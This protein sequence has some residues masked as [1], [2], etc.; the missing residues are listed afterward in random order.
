MFLLVDLFAVEGKEVDGDLKKTIGMVSDMAPA[1]VCVL[2]LWVGCWKGE[3]VLFGRMA[4]GG[5]VSERRM[6]SRKE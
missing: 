2:F 5:N 3:V 4:E 1:C 6:R